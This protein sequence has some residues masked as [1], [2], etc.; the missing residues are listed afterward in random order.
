[1]AVSERLASLVESGDAV[2][3][4]NLVYRVGLACAPGGAQGIV[5][6]RPSEE[7]G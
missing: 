3:H 4:A 5:P 6:D 2:T 7:A 1:M